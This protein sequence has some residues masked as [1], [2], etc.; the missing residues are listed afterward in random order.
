MTFAAV[1]R[2]KCTAHRVFFGVKK[3]AGHATELLLH[4]G[5]LKRS[6]PNAT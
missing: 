6:Q 4:Y 2:G 5:I 1:F 3:C